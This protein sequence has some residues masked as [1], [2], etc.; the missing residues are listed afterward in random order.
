MKVTHK[1]TNLNFNL[2]QKNNFLTNFKAL[3][4]R[5]P[6]K[7]KSENRIYRGQWTHGERSGRG[8]EVNL[9]ELSYYIG[10]FKSDKKDGF[11]RLVMQNG[12]IYE[13]EW[14]ENVAHGQG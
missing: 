1:Q 13:G 11:G 12:N 14:Q 8:I 4:N 6:V 10:E 2:F 9:E 7:F 3:E 5:G